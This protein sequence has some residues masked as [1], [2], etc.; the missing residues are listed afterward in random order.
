MAPRPSL[1]LDTKNQK[2][3]ARCAVS[4]ADVSRRNKQQTS[5]DNRPRRAHRPALGCDMIHRVEVVGGVVLP[6]HVSIAGGENAQH[7]VPPSGNDRTRNHRQRTVLAWAWRRTRGLWRCEPLTLSIADAHRGDSS[8]T[9][10]EVSVLLIC[11][12]AQ[13]NLPAKSVRMADGRRP[14]HEGAFLTRIEGPDF[15][16]LWP[17]KKR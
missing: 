6:Q 9:Q 2:H 5:R 10:S 12:T 1:P 17:G 4:D 7:A 13:P 16:A 15:P 11:R 3:V 8:R 14:P